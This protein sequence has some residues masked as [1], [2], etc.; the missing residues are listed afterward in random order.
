MLL[1]VMG[2]WPEVITI[3]LWSFAL[4]LAADIH[5]ATPGPSGKS[6]EEILSQQTA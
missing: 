4:K 6:P 2:H 1:H 3:D 5:N